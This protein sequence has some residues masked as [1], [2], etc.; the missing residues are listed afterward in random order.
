MGTPLSTNRPKL[1]YRAA[2]ARNACF[3]QS[4]I[5]IRSAFQSRHWLP[6]QDRVT[7]LEN[8]G[9]DRDRPHPLALVSQSIA[10][11]NQINKTD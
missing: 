6:L 3:C 11:T 1:A 5:R 8:F 9:K 7:K 2:S 10:T 4:F